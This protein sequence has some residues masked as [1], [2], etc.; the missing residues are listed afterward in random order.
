MKLDK[1]APIQVFIVPI[2][3]FLLI[4]C[5]ST[6][7]PVLPVETTPAATGVAPSVVGLPLT[8]TPTPVQ[9]ASSTPPRA[10][11]SVTIESTP[12]ATSTFF[13]YGVVYAY[14]KSDWSEADRQ[15]IREHLEYLQGLGINTIVQVFSSH[16]IGTG[17]E[18]DWLILLDEAEQINMHVVA[19]LWPLEDWNGQEFDFQ[20]IQSF[21]AVVQD[22]P[23]LLAYLG[24]HEPLEQFD[25]D[26]LREFYAGVK[27]LA[28][29]L[30][31]AHYMG[32]MALFENSSRFPNRDFTAGICDICIVWCTPAGHRDGKPSFEE[33]EV[34]ETLKENRKL[35]DERAPGAQL[36]FLGQTYALQAHRDQLRM[37]TPQEMEMIYAIAEQEGA[38]G[39]LWYPWLH[40]N[41]DQ[42]LSD[43]DM[44]P[45]RQAVRHIYETYILQDPNP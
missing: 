44:E 29:E 27:S 40:G 26:Q 10:S 33:A 18:K 25:S 17:R 8:P 43:P 32:N 6:S 20:P 1:T 36:W 9:G 14:S 30:P 12:E 15:D 23:A 24:L 16:L 45:Q 3:V 38:D 42:V 2:V 28:P 7:E 11:A 37:P 21:L 41:Y 34:H 4:G 5:T 35:V 31:I 22:H 19:R 13:P 39:F